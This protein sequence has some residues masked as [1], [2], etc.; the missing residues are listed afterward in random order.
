MIAEP[1]IEFPAMQLQKSG[2]RQFI[3]NWSLKTILLTLGPLA[4]DS[5]HGSGLRLSHPRVRKLADQWLIDRTFPTYPPLI[6]AIAKGSE[7]K[8]LLN[9]NNTGFGTLELPLSSI[10][11][12]CDGIHRIAALQNLKLPIRILN[13][14]EWPVEFIECRDHEDAANLIARFRGEKKPRHKTNSGTE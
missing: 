6:V 12:V 1:N 14:S 8:P 10:V 4:T 3:A 7:F 2:R 5:T 11:D 13:E 9:V